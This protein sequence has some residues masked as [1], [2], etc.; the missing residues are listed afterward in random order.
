MTGGTKM[1]NNVFYQLY[2]LYPTADAD[3]EAPVQ[4]IADRQLKVVI[5]AWGN[6]SSTLDRK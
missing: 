5:S 2:G 1:S 3:F 6:R 4:P